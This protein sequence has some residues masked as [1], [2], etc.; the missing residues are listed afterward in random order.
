MCICY[1][2]NANDWHAVRTLQVIETVGS[3]DVSVG[4]PLGQLS[5]GDIRDV[6][7]V[8]SSVSFNV[9][10]GSVSSVKL[11]TH[12]HTRARARAHT[13]TLSQLII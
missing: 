10:N 7:R 9:R 4:R 6:T 13:H 11:H 2:F 3:G 5:K 8:G 12:T 1:L